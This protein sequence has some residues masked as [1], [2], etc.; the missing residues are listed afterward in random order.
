MTVTNESNGVSYSG[1][2][3]TV[4]FDVPLF[5]AANSHITALHRDASGAET[6][7]VEGTHYT[8]AGAAD[9]DNA[10]LT[11]DTDPVDY[12]PQAGEKLFIQR[13]MP[14]RQETAYPAGGEFPAKA[15]EDALDYL[16]FVT[17]QLREEMDRAAVLPVSSPVSGPGLPEPVADKL[18]GWNAGG[19]A[20]ENKDAGGGGGGESNTASNTGSAGT[21]IWKQKAGVDLE[22]YK[23]NSLTA[24][25]TIALDGT[26]KVDLSIANAVAAGAAGLMTGS[27]KTKLDGVA[28]GANAYSHPNHSGDVT[29][30]G[31]G[32][33][34]IAASAVTTAKIND[35][36]VTTAKIG[37]NQVTYAKIQ[38]VTATARIL[39]R[40][41]AGA[42]LIEELTA[43]TVR[44]MLNVAN[45]ADVSPVAS[46]FGRTS[47]VVA[48][49]GDYDG[50]ALDLQD[51][52]LTRPF[53]KDFAETVKIFTGTATTSLSYADGN[54]HDLTLASV[55]ITTL[56]LTNWSATGRHGRM[57]IY[58]N[59][60]STA[61]TIAWP[62][63]VTWVGGSAPDLTTVSKTSIVV[64]TSLDAGT[65]I[66]GHILAEGV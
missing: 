9:P 62:A 45:G 37:D 64:L 11:V 36:A 33:T 28:S 58:I 15:H 26:D 57:T 43:A 30:A 60:G 50:L 20:L 65:T 32:A 25:F 6:A 39:G 2:G 16:T 52:L 7:W 21:G 56:N 29:S 54:V 17:Q 41:T 34:T 35:A 13:V 10:K 59:Q 19:T 23:I 38:N 42:G 55:D 27:D 14:F 18:L 47:S 51:A 24:A 46:V 48:V 4:I 49:A 8:L 66:Y 31:D 12:T 22:F 5:F 44:A 63:A 3:S 53:T 1:D 40:D 61:R